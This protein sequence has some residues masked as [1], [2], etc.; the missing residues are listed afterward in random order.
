MHD[1]P[2]ALATLRSLLAPSRGLWVNLG[3]LVTLVRVRARVRVRVRRSAPA[4][5]R[6]AGPEP[7]A[8]RALPRPLPSCPYHAHS[9]PVPWALPAPLL[10]SG[11][12]RGARQPGRLEGACPRLRSAAAA[13]TSRGLRDARGAAAG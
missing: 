9:R 8:A 2:A 11:V 1:L 10:L 5:R 13:D 12:S 3:P 7:M 6:P 4:T